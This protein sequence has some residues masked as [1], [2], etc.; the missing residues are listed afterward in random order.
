MIEMAAGDT[1][2]WSTPA[3]QDVCVPIM[4]ARRHDLGLQGRVVPHTRTS[5]V[6]RGWF[7]ATRTRASTAY[8]KSAA[9][10]PVWCSW[11]AYGNDTSVS[12]SAGAL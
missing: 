4:S 10:K 7:Q 8:P 11:Q 2:A 3:L 9:I 1:T 12:G 5:G 6:P